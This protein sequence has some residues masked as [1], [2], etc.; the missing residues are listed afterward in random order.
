VIDFNSFLQPERGWEVDTVHLEQQT[1]ASTAALVISNPSN[2]CGSVYSRQHLQD[3]LQVARG[4][5]VPVIADEIYEHMV[6][7]HDDPTRLHAVTIL[8]ES[9]YNIQHASNNRRN[10][11]SGYRT[12]L[13]DLLH[14]LLKS[15]SLS[16]VPRADV[17]SFGVRFRRRSN[18]LL[19]W[20]YKTVRTDK[21]NEKLTKSQTP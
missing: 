21:Q 5:F 3:I 17:L 11:S 1:D 16:G 12:L 2:P 8:E 7:I 9:R 14:V 19:Q 4:K 18:S 10:C 6:S 13:S 20:Y 15:V